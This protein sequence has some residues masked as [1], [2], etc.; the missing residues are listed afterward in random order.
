[1]QFTGQREDIKAKWE[2]RK[3]YVD[4]IRIIGE[5]ACCPSCRARHKRHTA[6]TLA[7]AAGVSAKVISDQLGHASILFTLERYSHLLPSIQDGAAARVE[8]WLMG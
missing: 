8:R 7:V 3:C 2:G 5:S 6:A 1:M 4:E